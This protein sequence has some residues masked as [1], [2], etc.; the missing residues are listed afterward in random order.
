[1][2]YI[3]TRGSAGTVTAGQAIE[4]G[5]A[6]DGGLY[7]PE[8]VPAF[9]GPLEDLCALPY[10][11]LAFTVLKQ[12]L[13]DYDEE[14]L[15]GYISAAY[16]YPSKFTH[17]EI[18][19][20]R[21]LNDKIFFLELFHG[22]TLAFK[23][24]ALSLLPS[25]LTA[26]ASR[27]RPGTHTLIL[28]ATSGDTGKAALEGFAG[29]DKVS[30]AVF[31]PRDGVSGMQKLQMLT[32]EGGNTYVVGVNGN[33][34]DTQT[35]VKILF[36]DKALAEKMAADGLVF[37]S[38]N[39]INI[40]RLLP[41]MVY[42]V[43]AY[44]RLREQSV[45]PKGGEV[46]FTV[47]TGNFGNI[48]AGY[49]A[50]RMGLPIRRLICA[51]NSNNVLTHFFNGGEYNANRD[52]YTTISPS[53]DILVSS[54]LERLLYHTCGDPERV[55]ACMGG[56]NET[57]RYMFDG[58]FPDITAAFAAEDETREAL[59]ELWRLGYLSD[60]HTAVAY[61]ACKQKRGGSVPNVI[62][63]TA[64]PFKFAADVYEALEG[65]ALEGFAAMEALS[66][67]S[68]IPVPAAL[69]GLRDKKIRHTTV[70]N[71]DTMRAALENLG[72]FAK[73]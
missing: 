71:Q 42:Y 53:M 41:Q 62:I 67:L 52:F 1:M 14:S 21:K 17:P 19:P 9:G 27:E 56:L 33:F 66:A 72:I 10:D 5:L 13:T 69:S 2:R 3:S 24:M 34:D 36:N 4:K 6:S 57:G 47:P 32:Q 37:S 68:G 38:A 8:T 29:A 48:L 58:S 51:S 7:V 25:L 23:D 50:K 43:Y 22:P 73:K 15:R 18:T 26:A 16:S 28:T 60:P 54:N 46:D 49:Y 40:G 39:S 35:G 45:I 64:S 31:Y 11:E 61:H 65:R 30:I 44:A 12:Y 63:S 70:C 59:R 20:L 55:R